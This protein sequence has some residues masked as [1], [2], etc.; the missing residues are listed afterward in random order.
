MLSYFA[1][2]SYYEFDILRDTPVTT[3]PWKGAFTSN[4]RVISYTNATNENTFNFTE[5]LPDSFEIMSSGGATITNNNNKTHLTWS[6]LNNNSVVSYSAR[7]PLLSPELYKLGPSF[8]GYDENVFYEARPWYLAADPVTEGLL[9]DGD[10]AYT[11]WGIGGTAPA[12]TRWQSVDDPIGSPDNLVTYVYSPANTNRNSFTF[13]NLT[14]SGTTGINWVAVSVR[15]RRQAG[16]GGTAVLRIFYRQGGTDYDNLANQSLTTAF[17]T[18]NLT[19]W[20]YTTN[21][22][23]GAPWNESAINNM[24]WGVFRAA[25]TVRANV[26]QMYITVDY[27]VTNNAPN[28]TNLTHPVD[29]SNETSSKIDFNFTITDD[30]ELRNCTLYTNVTGSWAPNLT[31]T[32]VI[33]DSVNNITVTMPDGN[34][35]WNIRCWDNITPYLDDWYDYNFTVHIDTTGPNTSIDYPPNSTNIS[36]DT[37]LLN[38][39]VIDLTGAD[40]VT[41]LYRQ[42]ASAAWSYACNDS[43]GPVYECTWDLTSLP[44]GKN[45]QIRAYANDTFGTIGNNDTHINITVDRTGPNTSLWRPANNTVIDVRSNGYTYMLNATV[46]DSLSTIDV[47]TFMYRV[48]NTDTWKLACQDTNHA[49]PYNCSWNLTTLNN[50]FDYQVLAYANDSLGNIGP[51]DTHINIT[52]FAKFINISYMIIDDSNQIDLQ[53]GTTKSVYCNITVSDPADYTYI[54][55]VNATFYSITNRSNSTDNNRTHYSNSSC[56]FL[57]GGGQSADYQCIF[58]VWHFAINGTWNCTG[59]AWDS[60]SNITL[61]NI[62]TVNQL[63]ALNVTT[64][65]INYTALQPNETSPNV[66]VNISNV[67]NMPMN[68]SV[69]GFG[70]DNATTGAG[71]SMICEINNISLSFEKYSVNSSRN[72]TLKNSLTPTQQDLGLTMPAK[73]NASDVRF[74]STYWQFMVPPEAHSFGQCN[75]SVV[76]V[77]GS[78]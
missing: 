16:G 49:V 54:Q 76:F 24:E 41:F 71:L 46:N 5:V 21:P 33:N 12:A 62:T 75:G 55:G 59:Y 69:Y 19:G 66:T 38:A 9:P 39:S 47:V 7:P 23:T 68:I 3:D 48:N 70:G 8:V 61:N 32:A 52:I 34:F 18:Y 58:N 57:T 42:N 67:G 72:Y 40:T 25:G 1:V 45:Y 15:A 22:R 27:N 10:G 43:R 28:V 78:P 2:K 36:T 26:T 31:G 6:N 35:L 44:D 30:K 20:N 77:A 50:S 4:I 17:V 60:Y 13:Q 51:N 74:N 14:M 63:F 37:Y 56:T 29:G 65:I 11:N 53:A 73:T 64:S